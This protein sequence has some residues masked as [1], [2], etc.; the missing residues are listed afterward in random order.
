[1]RVLGVWLVCLLSEFAS[2]GSWTK[3]TSEEHG[4]DSPAV[5]QG[6]VSGAHC[7]GR[8]CDNIALKCSNEQG[9]SSTTWWSPYFSEEGRNHYVCADGLMTGVRCSGR[10]CDNLSLRCQKKGSLSLRGCYWSQPFSEES[11][12]RLELPKGMH[13]VGVRCEGRYCDRKSLR[14]CRTQDHPCQSKECVHDMAEKFAPV[15]RFDQKQG[16]PGKCF[17][18]DAQSYWDTRKRGDTHS[19]FPRSTRVARRARRPA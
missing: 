17:P 3:A 9:I 10:Y 12:G 19:F 6:G 14:V 1:M 2:A 8:Y 5:C 13:V 15:L 16:R 18:Q 7:S 11:G 4:K